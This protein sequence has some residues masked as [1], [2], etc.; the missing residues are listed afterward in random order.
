M[1]KVMRIGITILLACLAVVVGPFYLTL[2]LGNASGLI[3]QFSYWLPVWLVAPLFLLF[4]IPLLALSPLV[5]VA[6]LLY[7]LWRPKLWPE[8]KIIR[9]GDD[10]RLSSSCLEQGMDK[11]KRVA[12]T[13]AL[14][15][16]AVLYLA[17]ALNFGFGMFQLLTSPTVPAIYRVVF[18]VALLLWACPLAVLAVGLYCLWQPKP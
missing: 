10:S 3:L 16:G 14:S 1:I 17:F 8:I 5:V 12:V 6:M 4:L 13:V 7:F 2:L 15:F 18:L 11:G 9:L